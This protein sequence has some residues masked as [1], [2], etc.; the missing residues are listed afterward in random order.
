MA[1]GHL[2][3]EN[4]LAA[5]VVIFLNLE[6]RVRAE[7]QG[8]LVAHP[9]AQAALG[10]GDE[11]VAGIDGGLDLQRQP[12]AAA[13]HERA[14]RHADDGA[15]LAARGLRRSGEGENRKQEHRRGQRGYCF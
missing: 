8:R 10:V 12:L 7:R 11:H 6:F 9:R 3:L 2:C 4:R 1:A 13:L 15:G 14:G 5:C